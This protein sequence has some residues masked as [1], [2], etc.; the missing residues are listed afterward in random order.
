MASITDRHIT[1]ELTIRT[2]QKALEFQRPE[3][4]NLILYGDQGS[5]YTSK[6]F[7]GFCE[8]V[9]VAQNM[10][11]AGY[12]YDNA[13]IYMNFGQMRNY[14][15]LWRNLLMLPTTMY[16]HTA[17]MTAVRHTRRGQPYKERWK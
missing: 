1:S 10:S 2:L 7:I 17:I 8:S 3:K 4:D 15:G 11:K 6:V 12:P 5:Q 16:I 13:P 14:T 9:H